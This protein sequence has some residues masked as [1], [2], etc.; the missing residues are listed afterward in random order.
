MLASE[1]ADSRLLTNICTNDMCSIF[2]SLFIRFASFFFF[3][4]AMV[5]T[6]QFCLFKGDF[7]VSFG[8]FLEGSFI[9][10]HESMNYAILLLASSIIFFCIFLYSPFKSSPA[11]LFISNAY[12]ASRDKFRG[13]SF[14]SGERERGC[15]ALIG[16]RREEP[17]S[18]ELR[19][20]LV[21][22]SLASWV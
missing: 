15:G 10:S 22:C 19:V 2:C 14:D 7:F 9:I 12:F 4:W 18:G 11:F 17:R 21:P 13:R 6:T 16:D 1:G 3:S 8:S 20:V 5:S